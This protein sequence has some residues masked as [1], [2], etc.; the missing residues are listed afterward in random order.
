M[1]RRLIVTARVKIATQVCVMRGGIQAEEGLLHNVEYLPI[2]TSLGT[3]EETLCTAML[4]QD[5]PILV[6]PSLHVC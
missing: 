3:F 2:R 1:I 6:I 4:E 5:P